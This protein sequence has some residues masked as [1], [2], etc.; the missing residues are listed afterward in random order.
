MERKNQIIGSKLTLLPI[1]GTEQ[2]FK[3]VAL[4]SEIKP[5]MRE[6]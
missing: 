2:Y 1:I 3:E 6:E 5:K 4:L